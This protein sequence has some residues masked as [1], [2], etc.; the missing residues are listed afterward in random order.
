MFGQPGPNSGLGFNGIDQFFIMPDSD[1]I[2][3]TT[4]DNRT[5]ETYFKVTEGTNR[6]VFYKEGAEV[7]TIK[8]YVENGNLH[9]GSYR[10]NGGTDKSIWFRT[11]VQNDTWY[12]VALVLDNASSLLFYLNGVLQAQNDNYFQL[13][14]HPG[15]FE[16][17]RTQGPARYPDCDTWGTNGSVD[18]CLGDVTNTDTVQLF[19]GGRI[20]GFRIWD[21]VRTAEEIMTNMNVLITDP[22]IPK[23]ED[24]LAY[25]DGD[26]MVFKDDNG[27][28]DTQESSGNV[29]DVGEFNLAKL[30]VY[31]EGNFI[32]VKTVNRQE[33]D[34]LVL[35]DLLGNRV[36]ETF[37][38]S[39]IAK[40]QLN[41][42][43]YIL[44]IIQGS[45]LVN[46]KVLIRN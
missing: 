1:N 44:R 32:K 28:F 39:S 45:N 29:L 36:G 35:Y 16:I 27:D 42:G 43:V 33:P 24:L 4:V 13:P 23:G 8:F 21:D 2:N 37:N 31:E 41:T 22:T 6:Q 38:N 34:Q 14:F 25:I 10:N 15:N 9:V 11:P 3:T 46:K 18:E 12:H 17:A 40:G 5:V 26:V 19:F 7:N 30:Q 20:W